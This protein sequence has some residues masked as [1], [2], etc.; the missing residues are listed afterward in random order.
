MTMTLVDTH[1]HLE[2]YPDPA[3]V[4]AQAEEAGTMMLA[5][6]MEPSDYRSTERLVRGRAC[7]IAAV[8]LHPTRAPQCGT[9]LPEL[10]AAMADTRFVGEVGLDGTV[11][12]ASERQAQRRVFDAVLSR[13]GELSGRVLTIHGRR[14]WEDVLSMLAQA[15]Q[16]TPIL[17]WFSGSID[18]AKRAVQLGCYFSVNTA[19]VGSKG[20]GE[21]LARVP[22][23]RV[24]LETDGPY[25]E[26]DGRPAGPTDLP[27]IAAWIGS[28]WRIP[29]ADAARRLA[30][31]WQR[32]AS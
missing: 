26:V 32:I 13:A 8:G 4:L 10:L 3:R 31:S 5:V 11:T 16:L 19:M 14:A 1:C 12:S 9:L 21:L 25:I 6:A 18:Q 29:E 30:R 7:A 17:H 24:L 20:A 15:A 2:R 27:H 22:P 28:V 23:D